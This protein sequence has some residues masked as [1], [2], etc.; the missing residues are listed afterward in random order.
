[1]ECGVEMGKVEFS[2][3]KKSLHV[4]HLQIRDGHGQP[5]VYARDVFVVLRNFNF[6]SPSLQ[7]VSLV[8]PCVRITRYRGEP[9]S[10]FKRVL[11]KIAAR[12]KKDSLERKPF[13]IDFMRVRD[14]SFFYDDQ[15]QDSRAESGVDFKHLAVRKVDLRGR[16]FHTR[17]GAVRAKVEHLALEES[18]GFVLKDFSSGVYVRKGI[19]RFSGCRAETPSSRI[20][21]DLSLEAPG[22]KSYAGFAE[23][24][25]L[26][27]EMKPSVAD[28]SDVRRF[29]PALGHVSGKVQLS[30]RFAG[31]VSDMRMKGFRLRYGQATFVDADF[32]LSGLPDIAKGNLDLVLR[33]LRVENRD[34]AGFVLPG[35]EPLALPAFLRDWRYALLSGSFKGGIERFRAELKLESDWGEAYLRNTVVDTGGPAVM[36]GKLQASSIPLGKILLRDSLFGMVDL[37]MDF[38]LSGSELRKMNCHFDGMASNLEIDGKRLSPVD[39]D[40]NLREDYYRG[41]VECRDRDLDFTLYGTIDHR[42]VSS[43][44]FYDLDLRNIDLQ[45]LRLMGDTGL[46]TA[47]THLQ[48][49]HTGS[50]LDSAQGELRLMNT[51]LH[52]MGRN[53]FLPEMEMSL[54]LHPG[55]NRRAEIRSGL[56][57]ADLEGYWSFSRLGKGMERLVALHLPSVFDTASSREGAAGMEFCGTFD[58]KEPDSLLAL[59]F[60]S[61]R[62]PAGMQARLDCA[63][64]LSRLELAVTCPFLQ[65]GKFACTGAG[66]EWASAPDA[67]GLQAR[68]ENFYVDDSLRLSVFGLQAEGLGPDSVAYALDWYMS[69]KRASADSVWW[70]DDARNSLVRGGM[71]FYP[72][73]EFRVGMDDC[74]LILRQSVW[75]NYPESYLFVAKDSLQFSH[76]GLQAV[77]AKG[78]FRVDGELSRRP[79]SLLQVEFHDFSLSDLDF[80]TKGLRMDM[81]GEMYGYARIH[82][83]YGDF[84][85]DADLGVDS[86][87]INGR[88]YGDCS[89]ESRFSRKEAVNLDLRLVEDWEGKQRETLSLEGTYYPLKG[90]RLDFSGEVDRLPV[91]FLQGMLSSVTD[92]LDGRM[93]GRL[94]IGG[95]LSRPELQARLESGQLSASIPLLGTRYR[96]SRFA[97][98]L[99]SERMVFD[100]CAFEEPVFQTGGVLRGSIGH[101]NFKGM[102]LDLDLD[103]ENLL[104]LDRK[105]S[106]DMP[107]WGTVFATGN[108]SV[109]GPV[110]DLTMLLSARVDDNSDISFDFSNPSGSTGANFITFASMKPE[111]VDS[112]YLSL[113]RTHLRNYFA[114]RRRNRL[115]MDLNLQVTPGL[116]VRVGLRNTAM[117]GTLDATG[118]GLLRLLMADGNTQ[119]FGTYTIEGGE[120]DFSMVD[121]INKR[122]V[123]EEGGTISW[124]GPMS[125]ARVNV[126]ADYQTKA[127]LYP[128][129]ASLNPS[130]DE[131]RQLKQSANVNSIIELTGNLMNPDIGFDIEL[132]NTDEDTRDRFFAVVKRDDE[133]EMLRQTFSLLMFNSF[134][135]VEGSSSDM[136][137]TALSSSFDFISSQ[138][139]NFLSKF[140]TDFN[141]GLN[142]RPRD[143][144]NNSEFQVVMSGQLFDDRLLING[145]LGVTDQNGPSAAT[146]ASTV[147]GEVDVEWKFTE[148]LRLRGFNHSND[149]DLTKPANSYT[150]GVGIVFKRDFD[151]WNEFVHGTKP[152]RTR[153]ERKAEKEKKREIRKAKQGLR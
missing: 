46:F 128:V 115:T 109:S 57:D 122:F 108:L 3:L 48:V 54:A 36:L 7:S 95:S 146:G 139:N 106:L 121:L 29:V 65:F 20:S 49:D 9:M 81:D 147:V 19:L 45:P 97:L 132:V 138:F 71:V 4:R 17:W 69:H 26:E 142:Y 143:Q 10:D 104:A 72:G 118:S 1:M 27:G 125:D 119:L 82:D 129:L 86:L 52:R 134:M 70:E 94:H 58:L 131:A 77:D 67:Y 90:N 116:A 62:I 60:P 152:R 98:E 23:N 145:N 140:T 149:Q 59:F 28:L 8:E 100:D 85:F 141:I 105:R 25:S 13:E 51:R 79:S 117:T 148:E 40:L 6:K 137:N 43:R 50:K 83:F 56:L 68:M 87:S 136:G 16:D 110:N 76:V 35:G 5:T 44:S 92:D 93:N 127:S 107:F 101:R 55:G 61:V 111:A 39:F 64:S 84:L 30:G 153:A 96:F 113:E 2:L 15:E 42:H 74:R 80:L 12:P 34:L 91:D 150:Q 38:R 75:K 32:R 41:R 18:S 102:R 33:Q 21:L 112:S 63:D 47:G 78:G 88:L 123:L 144:V 24:V 89:L 37:D 103:F 114:S 126:R 151:N 120:I 22:W 130:E 11:R 73:R 133:D 99:D 124:A 31:P 66:L 135:A 14:G 53:Y